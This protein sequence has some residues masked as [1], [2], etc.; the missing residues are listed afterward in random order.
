M[1]PANRPCSRCCA[2]STGPMPAASSSRDKMSPRLS[3]F[4]RV[5][6]G[7]G[8]HL[9]DQPRLPQSD[10]SPESRSAAQGRPRRSAEGCRGAVSAMRSSCSVSIRTSA[11][12]AREL[13]HH[14]LQWLEIAMVLAGG[15]DILLLDEPTAGMSPEETLQDRAGAAAS[16]RGGAHHRGGRARHCLRAGGC[17][18]GDGSAPGA[19]FRRGH[20]RGRSPRMRTC[21]GSISGGPER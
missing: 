10:R 3:A 2:A 4:R 12:L 18:Q 1:A 15:P 11:M 6:L 17:P 13:P 14:Q 21:A 20:G 8:P 7:V 9:P 5:R 16:E 19:C